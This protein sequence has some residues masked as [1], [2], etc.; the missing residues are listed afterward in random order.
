MGFWRVYIDKK[1]GDHA[2][3]FDCEAK[4]EEDALKQLKLKTGEVQGQ[5]VSLHED[6]R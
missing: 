2:R 3:V 6:P 5:V 1:N 4:D